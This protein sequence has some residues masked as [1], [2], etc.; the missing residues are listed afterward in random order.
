MCERCTQATAIWKGNID[1]LRRIEAHPHAGYANILK[2]GVIG[3]GLN[4][5]DRIFSILK[6]NGFNGWI[7]IEDG[8][9]PATGVRDIEESAHFL[10]KKMKEYGLE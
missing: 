6:D 3:R 9:D 2:H 5:Y 4:D 8:P 1:D 10:R 7:S